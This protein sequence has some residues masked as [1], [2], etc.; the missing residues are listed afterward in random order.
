MLEALAKAPAL[1]SALPGGAPIAAAC[2][3]ILQ[4]GAS[5]L[6]MAATDQPD[7][8]Q[9]QACPQQA[10]C[11]MELMQSKLSPRRGQCAVMRSARQQS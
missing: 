8:Q 7:C 1:G 4:V 11:A 2:A 10:A 6:R 9:A 3:S 5:A